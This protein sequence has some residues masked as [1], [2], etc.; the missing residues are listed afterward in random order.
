M[1]KFVNTLLYFILVVILFGSSGIW[2]PVVLNIFSKKDIV[3]KDVYQ[4]FSTFIIA[5]IAA[6]C[7]DLIISN[8]KNEKKKN[9]IGH[10][11]FIILILIIS[12]ALIFLEFYWILQGCNEHAKY[13]IIVG[14]TLAITL[15]WISNWNSEKYNSYNALGGEINQ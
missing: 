9:K 1:E 5:L 2:A 12:L 13:G 6:G 4:N 15:W 8:L 3:L 10:V 11:L 7:V 14:A